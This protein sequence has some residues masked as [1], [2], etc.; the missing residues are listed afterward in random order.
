MPDEDFSWDDSE[1]VAV[2]AIA[3]Y[4][5]PE[6]DIVIR[7]QSA[8][9]EDDVWVVI[10]RGRVADVIAALKREADAP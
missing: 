1:S 8:M 3:V 5:N 6:G 4:S 2:E 10:P 9:G 7:Q